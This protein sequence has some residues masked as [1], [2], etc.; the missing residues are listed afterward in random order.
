LAPAILAS[1]SR[2]DRIPSVDPNTTESG[3]I[4]PRG[5]I[6][7]LTGFDEVLIVL[8]ASATQTHALMCIRRTK[9]RGVNTYSTRVVYLIDEK[10]LTKD[11]E[12]T[13]VV[14][15]GAEMW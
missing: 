11:C 10:Q 15:G 1:R 13:Y 9:R 7:A 14:M 2:R 3:G 12:G 6:S 8:L 5:W 4:S